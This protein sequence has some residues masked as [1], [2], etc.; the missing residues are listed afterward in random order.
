MKQN[1][2]NSQQKLTI[3]EVRGFHFHDLERIPS[4]GYN[5]EPL[6]LMLYP[7]I[8]IRITKEANATFQHSRPT[9]AMQPTNQVG[10]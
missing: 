6:E 4:E 7:N 10:V 5:F 1:M 2:Q 9:Y 8:L 3:G